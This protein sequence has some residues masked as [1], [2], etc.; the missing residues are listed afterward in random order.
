MTKLTPP[1]LKQCQT[2]R[3]NG[4]SFLSFGGVVGRVRCKGRAAWIAIEPPRDDGAPRGS[5]SVCH[6]CQPKCAR[7]MPGATFRRIRRKALQEFTP[8]EK[9]MGEALKDAW[10]YLGTQGSDRPARVDK[11]ILNALEAFKAAGGKED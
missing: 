4:N 7:S 1:D 11:K 10:R 3:S 5:M 8:L 9:E 2:L 6:A